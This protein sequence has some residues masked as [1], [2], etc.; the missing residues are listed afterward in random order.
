M[1]SLRNERFPL[2][3]QLT[4]MLKSCF[5]FFI[6]LIPPSFGGEKL[7]VEK[8]HPV[9]SFEREEFTVNHAMQ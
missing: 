8:I 1:Q 7:G 6:F 3:C 4:A 9:W 2:I 5:V